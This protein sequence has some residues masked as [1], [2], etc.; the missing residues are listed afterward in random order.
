M[1][2]FLHFYY[3]FI[4]DTNQIPKF[5]QITK[6]YATKTL[7]KNPIEFLHF[8]Y[9]FIKDAN[10]IPKFLVKYLNHMFKLV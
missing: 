3:E 2:N 5:L 6:L 7:F 4:R 8:Y 1:I 9:E 10:Q